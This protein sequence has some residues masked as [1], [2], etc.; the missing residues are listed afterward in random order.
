MSSAARTR[1][2]R[3]LFRLAISGIALLVFALHIAGQ[4]RYEILDRVENY[5]YDVRIRMTMPGTVD[6]RIVII[7]IDESSQQQLG[8][9]P[10]PRKT[11]A[12]IVDR[13]FDD[14]GVT[15]LGLDVLFAEAEETSARR[16]LDELAAE[17]AS[18]DV[19][20]ELRAL[21]E[22]ADG[23]LAF[24]ESLIARDVVT[25]FVF[26]DS[27]SEGEPRTSGALPR[28]IISS[29]ELAAVD[30]PFVTAAGYTGSLPALQENAVD[31][32]FFDS[33]L[34][35]SDGVFRRSPLVQAYEGDL[36]PSLALAVARVA[37]GSPNVGLEFA[38]E[39]ELTGINL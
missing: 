27:V 7:D 17:S 38:S 13:L 34:I 2:V 28:P 6:D 12:R 24:A 3:L 9:W 35:D 10:W 1:T 30:V 20:A 19:I 26:K 14:Y 8:Q 31:G 21:A 15:V 23:N 4:P 32:G 5:L 18:A 36:Y 16:L 39:D 25:G 33:P 37:L 29:A 11:L 22:T